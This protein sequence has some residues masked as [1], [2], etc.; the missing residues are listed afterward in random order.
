MA[1][2]GSSRSRLVFV[3][4]GLAAVVGLVGCKSSGTSSTE[5]AAPT[6][7]TVAPGPT[8]APAPPV[9]APR[10]S[11]PTVA[12]APAKAASSSASLPEY[13]PS[14]VI[15]EA[16]EHTQLSSTDDVSKVNAFYAAALAKNGWKMTSQT[17]TSRSGN[18]IAKRSGHGATV[19]IASTGSGASISI[20]TYPA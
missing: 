9:S 3:V 7:V 17:V 20:S 4:G 18:F 12:P 11:P 16:G 14:T 13:R 2:T 19:A 1:I 10:V 6:V 15:S 8:I 5:S